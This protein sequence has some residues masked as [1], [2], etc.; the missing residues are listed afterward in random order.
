MPSSGILHHV[1]MGRFVFALYL[2]QFQT[3]QNDICKCTQICSSLGQRNIF[4]RLQIEDI[5][6]SNACKTG[7]LETNV[8]PVLCCIALVLSAGGLCAVFCI[9][10]GF[11]PGSLRRIILTASGG[12]FRDWPAADLAKVRPRKMKREPC[13]RFCCHYGYNNRVMLHTNVNSAVLPTKW[14]VR[15]HRECLHAVLRQRG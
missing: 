2:R 8:T 3:T 6:S 12:A 4:L 15:M 1:T 10:Q 14:D 9:L 13:Q 11:P 5:L 7:L